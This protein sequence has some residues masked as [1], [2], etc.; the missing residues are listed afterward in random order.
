M[1]KL[2]LFLMI[3]ITSGM[4]TNIAMSAG[5][6]DAILSEEGN[7]TGSYSHIT[8]SDLVHDIVNHPA[9]KSFGQYILP[10]GNN[11]S[12]YDMSLKNVHSLLPYHNHVDPGVVVDAINHMIDEINDGKTLFYDFYTEKQKQE[13]R[14]K[15]ST[16]LFF[17]RGKP[18]APFAIVCPGG[19]FAYV[20]SLHEGFPHAIELS[21]KGYNAFVLK[22]R[23]GS[24]FQATE[25]LAAAISYIFKKA[26]MFQISV[27][28]YSLWGSSAG[29]RM[30]GNIAL[31]GTVRFGGYDLPKP[32]IVVIAY[33]GH[34]SFSEN[35]PPTFITVSED[36]GIVNV[37]VVDRRV[38][39]LRNIGIEVEYRKYKNAG[40]GFGLGVGTDAEGWIEHGIQ[41]WEN[42][43]S[44]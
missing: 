25:D 3:F 34:T 22:Y 6:T 23:V 27:K 8:T 14:A 19:G 38:Q 44:K 18:E 42:H 11:T 43:L 2:L 15:K 31:N 9:F 39:S 7:G 40:H 24:E 35:Y 17:F 5:N 29:A 4:E 10:W 30:V 1:K 33:T 16:G 41:F 36:D 28:N 20:G 12:Y 13:V 21:K 26:E 32:R 37:S